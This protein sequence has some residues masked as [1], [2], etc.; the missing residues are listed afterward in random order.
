MQ[1][2]AGDYN[3]HEF[4]GA[5]NLPIFEDKGHVYVYPHRAF[6]RRDGYTRDVGPLYPGKEY[7]NLGYE[8]FRAELLLRP[9]AALEN[10]TIYRY[11]HSSD[12]GPG[13]SLIAFNPNAGT[14]PVTVTAFF[15][16]VPDLSQPAIGARSA[17][18]CLQ[19]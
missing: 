15:P 16:N 3:D 9:V 7:D 12:D 10:Y 8:S 13:T 4:E 14:P 18:G 1:A 2:Q 5:L 19:H 6:A 17:R 11:Y